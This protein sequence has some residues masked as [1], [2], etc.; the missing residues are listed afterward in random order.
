MDASGN[1]YSTGWLDKF[2]FSTVNN[3]DNKAPIPEARDLN[4]GYSPGNNNLN[5]G[6]K[7][8]GGRRR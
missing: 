4:Q 6:D 1:P 2:D 3:N 5:S 7:L 8:G